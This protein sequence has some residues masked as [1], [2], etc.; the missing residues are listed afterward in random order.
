[1]ENWLSKVRARLEGKSL[2]EQIIEAE[3]VSR[4]TDAALSDVNNF[5][6]LPEEYE[7]GDPFSHDPPTEDEE[8]AVDAERVVRAYIVAGSAEEVEYFESGLDECDTGP[9]FTK[10]ENVRGRQEALGVI[11]SLDIPPDFGYD[12]IPWTGENENGD[13]I[14]VYVAWGPAEV[15]ERLSSSVSALGG[16]LT[17]LPWHSVDALVHATDVAE[18]VYSNASSGDRRIERLE[19]KMGQGYLKKAELEELVRLKVEKAL[20]DRGSL[21]AD[22]AV[23]VEPA[24]EVGLSPKRRSPSDVRYRLRNAYGVR[25]AQLLNY[26]TPTDVA[27]RVSRRVNELLVQGEDIEQAIHSA[28]VGEAVHLG[29]WD[30]I[31]RA[32]LRRAVG[33]TVP[34]LIRDGCPRDEAYFI[35]PIIDRFIE[36]GAYNL[37]AFNIACSFWDAVQ[38]GAGEEIEARKKVAAG[39]LGTRWVTLFDRLTKVPPDFPGEPKEFPSG[40]HWIAR[41]AVLLCDETKPLTRRRYSMNEALSQSFAEWCNMTHDARMEI[42]QGYHRDKIRE[43]M[44]QCPEHTGGTCAACD[45]I[46]QTD[47]ECEELAFQVSH[48]ATTSAPP[49]PKPISPVVPAMLS[50]LLSTMPGFTQ[51]LDMDEV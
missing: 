9:E 4:D 13:R 17:T 7:F 20:T 49:Q 37:T 43:T 41:T 5:L 6:N 27:W 14:D 2:A 50:F 10:E 12:C 45:F 38:K 23:E 46:A 33:L 39:L 15:L 47:A 34:T 35:A 30:W 16:A 51:L 36:A 40:A 19:K 29:D 44:K 22:T 11:T 26:G 3:A 32:N 1:M 28:W 18:D 8:A 25:E 24:A 31:D 21:V 42:R 48:G